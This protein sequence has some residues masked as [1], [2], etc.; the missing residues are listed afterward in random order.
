MR[1]K[2]I[3]IWVDFYKFVSWNVSLVHLTYRV[4]VL[5]AFIVKMIK[6]LG[7]GL[8]LNEKSAKKKKEK[9]AKKR[10]IIKNA[11]KERVRLK[12]IANLSE[13]KHGDHS[14]YKGEFEE[15]NREQFLSEHFGKRFTICGNKHMRCMDI[16]M[17]NMGKNL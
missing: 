14:M 17:T 8:R 16:R 12:E 6:L 15:K 7:W 11:E 9:S 3:R 13:K 4:I 2:T 1:V 5:I 10:E